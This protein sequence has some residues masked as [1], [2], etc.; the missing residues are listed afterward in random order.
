MT[1]LNGLYP[2]NVSR[3][4]NLAEVKKT[5]TMYQ[6]AVLTMRQITFI[7]QNPIYYWALGIYIVYCSC[8]SLFIWLLFSVKDNFVIVSDCMKFWIFS[9]LFVIWTLEA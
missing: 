5:I 4:R 6:N 7:L 3:E 8:H 1:V 2:L 9:V